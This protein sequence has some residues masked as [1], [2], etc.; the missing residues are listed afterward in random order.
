[1][2]KTGCS[3]PVSHLSELPPPLVRVDAPDGT[4]WMMADGC[5]VAKRTT[6]GD[7]CPTCGDT[8]GRVIHLDLTTKAN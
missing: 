6:G 3:D 1:M 5:T 2:A 8:T 7:I 4:T